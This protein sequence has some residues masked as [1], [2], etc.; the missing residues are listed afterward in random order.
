MHLFDG[1]PQEIV[2][3][4]LLA[5]WCWR[6]AA[7]VE[8]VIAG[9]PMNYQDAGVALEAID[10]LEAF[11][12]SYLLLKKASLYRSKRSL[13]EVV[14][15][16]KFTHFY[17][18]I[19]HNLDSVKIVSYLHNLPDPKPYIER[20]FRLRGGHASTNFI[21]A[22]CTHGYLDTVKF[23]HS[24]LERGWSHFS[25]MAMDIA[26]GQGHLEVVEWLHYNR[27]EGCS[28]NALKLAAG[29][30]HLNVVQFLLENRTERDIGGAMTKAYSRGKPLVLQ[31]LKQCDLA[32]DAINTAIGAGD[33]G[34]LKSLA[35]NI[36]LK[37]DRVETSHAI[38]SGFLDIVKFVHEQGWRGNFRRALDEAAG[39][40]HLDMVRFLHEHRCGGCT[41]SAMDRAA[42][43]G[44]LDIVRFLH[45]NRQE[46]CTSKALYRAAKNGY[47]DVVRFLIENRRKGDITKALR[48]ASEMGHLD[49]VEFLQEADSKTYLLTAD[50]E[51]LSSMEG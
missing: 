40:G 51:W 34:T 49:V 39:E 9:L 15:T 43:G 33:V 28:E 25:R 31:Y 4:I 3:A 38:C 27:N 22:A 5:T 24:H 29:G 26:A 23:L 48:K 19:F 10:C 13:L 46:G 17:G 44:Y 7:R 42:A 30:G 35:E 37:V 6:T 50:L 12:A 47:L 41:A 2:T 36:P 18:Q 14:L 32:L 20:R 45:L 8:A 21:N 11:P 16:C 1:L